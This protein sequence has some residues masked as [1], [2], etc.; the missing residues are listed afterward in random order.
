MNGDPSSLGTPITAMSASSRSRSV[1][2]TER[3][4][5]GMPTNGAFQRGSTPGCI[6][7]RA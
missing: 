1:A 3:K 5:D 2:M 4:K 6:V 7:A